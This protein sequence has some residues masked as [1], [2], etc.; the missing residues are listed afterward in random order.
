MR[1]KGL[2]MTQVMYLCL[3]K[4]YGR[5]KDAD[6]AKRAFEEMRSHNIRPALHIY[7]MLVRILTD[8]GRPQDAWEVFQDCIK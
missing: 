1:E 7:T 4:A 2:Q 3:I 8:E 6:R 5:C